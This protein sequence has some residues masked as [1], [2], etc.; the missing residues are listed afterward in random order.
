MSQKDLKQA[1]IAQ[2]HDAESFLVISI[3]SDRLVKTVT[4]FARDLEAATDRLAVAGVA[5]AFCGLV[6]ASTI[7]D[8]RRILEK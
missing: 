8:L 7:Q 4:H 5:D 3:G 6:H 2:I 1:A